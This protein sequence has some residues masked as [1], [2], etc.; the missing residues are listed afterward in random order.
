LA[1]ARGNWIARLDDDDI[2]TEDH[3]EVLLEFAIKGNYEFVSSMYST[4][5]AVIDHDHQFPCAGGVQTWLYRDYLKFMKY[6]PDCWRKSWNRV[7][8]VDLVH[9]FRNAGVRMGWLPEITAYVLPRPGETEVGLK[10]YLK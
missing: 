2:W 8:D 5:E 9:R 6:N 7:N 1:A 3:L 10:A 4:H